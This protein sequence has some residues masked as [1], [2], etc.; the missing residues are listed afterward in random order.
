MQNHIV[1]DKRKG[2]ISTAYNISGR[3]IDLLEPSID[4]QILVMLDLLRTKYLASSE[5]PYPPLLDFSDLSSYLTMDIITR[6]AFGQEFGHMKTDSDVTGFLTRLRGAWPMVSLLNE[7][8]ALR[9]VLYSRTFLSLFG[10]KPTDV[11]GLGKI[12]S[13]VVKIVNERFAKPASQ[14]RKDMLGSWIQHGVTQEECEAEGLLAIIAGSETTASVMRMT[15][16]CLLSSPK[17]YQK[18]KTVVREAVDSG[19]LPH[20]ISYEA[21]K[22][23][24]Y[25]RAIIYEGLRMRPGTTGAFSKVVPPQGETVQ[26]V[27]VPGGT[28]IAMNIPFLLRSADLFGCDPGLFR[29]ERWIEAADK[30]RADMEREVEMMFGSGRWMCAGKPIAFMELYKTFFELLHH[31]DFQIANP[32]KPWDSR[33][34]N[35]FVEENMLVRVE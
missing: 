3:E 26:G 32:G 4:E 19:T 22:S 6:A 25:L 13:G 20:P 1:H 14:T 24:P 30:Q 9:T 16:L 17:I 7:W 35:V 5:N 31:F 8:P 21:A 18:L 23:I 12:M 15:F 29:P 28:L 27:F 10:P 33:C 11:T 2:Q 34:Y